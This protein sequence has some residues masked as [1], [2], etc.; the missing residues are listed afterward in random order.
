MRYGLYNMLHAYVRRQMLKNFWFKGLK[1]R[2]FG[3]H[4][5]KQEDNI[6]IEL[7]DIK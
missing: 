7:E 5:L 4:R 1:E 6:K 2:Q 3:R